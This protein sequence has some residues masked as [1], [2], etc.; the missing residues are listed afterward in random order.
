MGR[1]LDCGAILKGVDPR[2]PICRA[3][4]DIDLIT[5]DWER[6]QTLQKIKEMANAHRRATR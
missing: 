1:C 6:K 4:K 5:D 3:I 2:C